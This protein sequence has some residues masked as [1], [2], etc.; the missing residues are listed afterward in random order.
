[1]EDNDDP[2][3][4][5]Q[6]SKNL[7]VLKKTAPYSCISKKL[8]Y[9]WGC[10]TAYT[11]VKFK[12]HALAPVGPKIALTSQ[13]LCFPLLFSLL[14]ALRAVRRALV[15]TPLRAV[16][17]AAVT[18]SLSPLCHGN[19]LYFTAFVLHFCN[20]YMNSGPFLTPFFVLWVHFGRTWGTLLPL[21]NEKR[22]PGHPH[23]DFPRYQ[24]NFRNPFRGEFFNISQANDSFA[25]IIFQCCFTVTF[26]MDSCAF[27]G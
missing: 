23:C 9:H 5:N 26:L 3:F 12:L 24:V 22:P 27:H 15:R 2:K 25:G 21:K 13:N 17:R 7:V 14:Q 11:R 18:A 4:I 20:L 16:R 19:M 6:F 10:R 1:M 8:A